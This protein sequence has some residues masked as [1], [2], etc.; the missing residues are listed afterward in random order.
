MITEIQRFQ[1]DYKFFKISKRTPET[2]S[3]VCTTILQSQALNSKITNDK[4]THPHTTKG[5]AKKLKDRIAKECQKSTHATQLKT[6]YAA[7]TSEE[8]IISDKIR[9][10]KYKISDRQCEILKLQKQL[11]AYEMKNGSQNK[12]GYLRTQVNCLQAQIVKLNTLVRDLTDRKNQLHEQNESI[13]KNLQ[14]CSNEISAEGNITPDTL[15]CTN[16]VARSHQ[17]EYQN[18]NKRLF[19]DVIRQ[20]SEASQSTED[21]NV[22][23][24]A[25]RLRYSNCQSDEHQKFLKR[26]YI[27]QKRLSAEY[28]QK[29]N[30]K[31]RERDAQRRS[32]TEFREKENLKQRERD[33]QRR[34]STEFREKENLK[35]RER[36]AQRRSSTEF[37]EKENLKQRE[38][39]AQRRS[40][41]EFREKE[42]L[43]QREHHA[44]RRSSTEFRQKDNL[45]QRERHA[46]RRTS[47][48]FR[49]KE[50]LKQREHHAQ[51]H[52]STEFREKENLK[53]RERNAQRRSSTEFRQKDNLKQRERHAQR[54]TSTEFRQKENLK[55]REHHAQR[56]SS[57][58]LRDNEKEREKHRKAQKLHQRS[59]ETRKMHTNKQGHYYTHMETV[60]LIPLKSSQM[61][62][63]KVQYMCVVHVYK[64]IL[65]TV[66]LKYQHYI[67]ENTNHFWQ[68]V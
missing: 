68:N 9:Y 11:D 42:N 17:T 48:E 54:R 61:L 21:I 60:F 38:R 32:S 8:N 13:R 15:P 26:E 57:T 28:R 14:L 12:Y 4:I 33:A 10:T 3:A 31:Q 25:K 36:N 46:Q 34:S 51:R 27:R 64:Q 37:R 39:D 5:P 49:Q 43:K 63:H 52:S 16:S 20:T 62:Y 2:Y 55:Q 66:L 29:E 40:S 58:E 24:P 59:S 7:A 65:Q 56:R 23:L 45:K 22:E 47:T 53:Q 18:Q 35:Q 41:T 19:A 67:L 1:C 30:L 44:Q 6:K 50:N